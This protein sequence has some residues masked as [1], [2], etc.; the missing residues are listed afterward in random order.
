M[1]NTKF[2]IKI[3]F[4]TIIAIG[5]FALFDL[6]LEIATKPRDVVIGEW[7]Y[8]IPF[9]QRI[10]RPSKIELIGKFGISDFDKDYALVIQKVIANRIEI[11]VNGNF[12]NAFGDIESGNLWPAAFVQEIPKNVLKQGNELRLVLYG[13]VGYGLSYKPYVTD[14]KN[15]RTTTYWIRLLRNDIGIISVGM[16]AIIAYFLIFA[17]AVVDTFERKSYLYIGFGMIFTILSLSQFVYRETTGSQIIY[18]L[19]EISSL[20][21]PAFGIVFIYFGLKESTKP[22]RRFEKILLLIFPTVFAI[23]LF[24]APSGDNINKLLNFIDLYAFAMM[25]VVLWNII[26]YKLINYYFPT[27]FLILTAL[28][29][30][31]VI[32]SQLPSEL[33]IVYGRIIFATYIG[34]LTVRKFKHISESKKFFERE[35]LIDKLTETYNRKIIDHVKPSGILILFDLDGFKEINDKYGHIYGDEIL[36]KF[37]QIVK[38]HIRHGED[39]FIRLGGDEFCIITN[40]EDVS[41][42]MERI[43]N[44]SRNEIGLGFS[45]GFAS[46]DG[47][48]FDNAYAIADKMMYE[49][50]SKKQ[51]Y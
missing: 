7:N 9:F 4:L 39:Y 28:Q 16:I 45:Y 44:V 1:R 5:T 49:N 20:V 26:K 47:N 37:A 43:Y 38:K 31:Y 6:L 23:A 36:K 12:L 21:F 22:L 42:M 41:G 27:I 14:V 13:V 34:T 24:S 33:T 50:K 8:E 19:A 51:K 10:E 2:S 32:T 11:Y 18:L 25:F 46:L 3:L 15:A 48:T 17:Y 35:N 40:S 29:T 30:L